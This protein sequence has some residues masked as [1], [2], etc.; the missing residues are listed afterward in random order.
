MGL[1]PL[2]RD[3]P[4]GKELGVVALERSRSGNGAHACI[5]FE[6]PVEARLARQLAI[7]LLTRT[8]EAHYR[9]GLDFYDGLFP[10]RTLCPRAASGI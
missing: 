1:Y 4:A 5:F 6:T 10:L 8:L 3:R 7:A 9:L 2:L